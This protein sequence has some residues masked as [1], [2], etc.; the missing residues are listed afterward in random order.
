MVIVGSCIAGIA[1][2]WFLVLKLC[3]KESGAESIRPRSKQEVMQGYLMTADR[4][5][6]DRE[7]RQR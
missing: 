2:K 6:W 5:K 7:A 4:D 1:A 3:P